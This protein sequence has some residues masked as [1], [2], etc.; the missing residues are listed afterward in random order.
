MKIYQIH[1]YEDI[2]FEDVED[3]IVGSYLNEDKAK[4]EKLNFEEEVKARKN[5]INKC[6]NCPYVIDKNW[7]KTISQIEKENPDFRCRDKDLSEAGWGNYCLNDC[8][9]LN[10]ISFKLVEVN[11]IE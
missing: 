10:D 11:V 7:T 2:E 1:K 6:K 4:E 5:K 3:T 9:G 8:S